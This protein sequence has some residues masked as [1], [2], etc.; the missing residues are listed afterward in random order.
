MVAYAQAGGE[1]GGH[2][3]LRN[4]RGFGRRSAVTAGTGTEHAPAPAGV[5]TTNP[6]QFPVTVSPVAQSGREP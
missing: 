1:D 5:I 6:A 2:G 4:R 3:N